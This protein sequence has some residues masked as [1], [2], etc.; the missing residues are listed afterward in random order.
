MRFEVTRA[1]DTIEEHL[2]TDPVLASAVVDLESVIRHLELDGGRP[3]NLLRLGMMIDALAQHL[4][5]GTVLLYAVADRAL[6]ADNALTSNEKMVVRRWADDGLVELVPGLEDRVLEV[7]AHTGLPVISRVDYSGYASQHP[8]LGAAPERL[9]VPLPGAGGAVLMAAGGAGTPGISRWPVEVDPA[10]RAAAERLW[11]CP[12][13]GCPSFDPGRPANQPPPRL[14]KRVP[15]CP[16]HGERLTDA[17]PRPPAIPMIVRIGGMARLRFAV[18][19]ARPIVVGRSPDDQ[20]GVMLGPLLD[21]ENAGRVSRN[22]VVLQLHNGGLA[23]G[24]LSTN[25]TTLLTRT[26]PDDEPQRMPLTRGQQQ[27]VGEW[28]T[29]ALYDGVEVARADRSTGAGEA[30]YTS[31]L[32][33][34]PTMAIRLP[35]QSP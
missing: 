16:R 14:R 11:R 18:S 26:G 28:D 5:D 6:L 31:V 20:G 35:G 8:W 29:V 27:W 30:G 2:S 24:D 10:A 21:E 22:H 3:A 17:G 19:G 1:L 9:L 15:V 12:A 4:G 25:G 23:V 33:E 32:A 7:A 34:A 13:P